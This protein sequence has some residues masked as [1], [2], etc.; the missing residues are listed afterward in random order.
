MAAKASATVTA[1]TTSAAAVQTPVNACAFAY[2]S[3]TT[4]DTEAH[5]M[6]GNKQEL[7]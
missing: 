5:A 1:A 2:D 6:P 4:I 7:L 3:P